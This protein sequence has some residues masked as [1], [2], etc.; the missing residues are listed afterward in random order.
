MAIREGRRDWTDT[1]GG[2]GLFGLRLPTFS[3]YITQAA[4]KSRAMQKP[5]Q[6]E[7]GGKDSLLYIRREL[8]IRSVLCLEPTRQKMLSE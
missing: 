6:G 8:S 7:G 3:K 4:G 5:G 2:Q 1:K